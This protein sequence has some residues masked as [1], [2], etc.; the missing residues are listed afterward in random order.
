MWGHVSEE[1]V[2]FTRKRC[3]GAYGGAGRRIIWATQRFKLIKLNKFCYGFATSLSERGT[4]CYSYISSDFSIGRQKS[5]L[6][7]NFL[8]L[9]TN[10]IISWLTRSVSRCREFTNDV[11]EFCC[12]HCTCFLPCCHSANCASTHLAFFLLLFEQKHNIFF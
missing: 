12:M 8:L 2:H 6:P 7:E 11:E 4:C 3:Q 5:L 9:I 10:K 1:G